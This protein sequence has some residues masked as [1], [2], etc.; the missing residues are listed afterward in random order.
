M[1]YNIY[2]QS[3]DLELCPTCNICMNTKTLSFGCRLCFRLQ[4]RGTYL[5]GPVKSSY[6]QSLGLLVFIHLL[7]NGQSP[8]KEDLICMH[9]QL[10]FFV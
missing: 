3:S 10:S 6:Y 5:V 1:M 7:H 9:P 4:V 8:R 2:I